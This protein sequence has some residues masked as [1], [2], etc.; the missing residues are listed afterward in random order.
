LPDTCRIAVIADTHVFES[1]TR[2]VPSQVSEFVARL[3]PNLIVHAGDICT[4]SVLESLAEIAPVLAVR[5]NN[6]SGLFGGSLPEHA[7]ILAG[8]H[9]FAIVH[10]HGGLSAKQISREA[11]P[12]HACVIYGHSH[13]PEAK[14]E[15]GVFYLNPGSPCDRRWHPHFGVAH[16]DMV[17]GS[18]SPVLTVFTSPTEL[19]RI[20]IEP[21]SGA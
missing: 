9:K 5:G 12:G 1:G 11:G 6:D 18:F 10:G 21:L 20:V 8:A 14:S 2:T 19:D 13:L 16:I 4:E 17:H 7:T 15:R 3:D